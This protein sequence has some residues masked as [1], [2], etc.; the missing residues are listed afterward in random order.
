MN[1]NYTISTSPDESS[2][3]DGTNSLPIDVTEAV[4]ASPTN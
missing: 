4:I 1:S 3:G 2:K